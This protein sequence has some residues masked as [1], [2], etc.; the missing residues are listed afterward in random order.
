[1][2]IGAGGV[3]VNLAGLLAR[4]GLLLASA[5]ILPESMNGGFHRFR[6]PAPFVDACA[7]WR[8]PRS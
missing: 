1:M 7:T 8:S 5:N 3:F 2:P 4:P 6:C